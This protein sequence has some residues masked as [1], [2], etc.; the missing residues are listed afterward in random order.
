MTTERCEQCG[1]ALT[2]AQQHNANQCCSPACARALKQRTPRACAQCGQP[3]NEQRRRFCGSACAKAFRRHEARP[4]SPP[5]H[6]TERA[7][8]ISL[9]DPQEPAQQATGRVLGREPRGGAHYELGTV[10]GHLMV[11]E[12]WQGRRA[13][14]CAYSAWE[15]SQAWRRCHT[16]QPVVLPMGAEPV[17]A[18]GKRR[19]E[20][21]EG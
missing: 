8:V 2:P 19:V 15:G 1:R 13:L 14:Y 16:P 18:W 3:T 4:S 6:E 17:T 11:F 10:N 20:E 7:C 12:V 9:P 5:A 21:V